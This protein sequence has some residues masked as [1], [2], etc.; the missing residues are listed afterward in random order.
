[1]SI[2]RTECGTIPR[3]AFATER[4]FCPAIT[5]AS[6]AG[7]SVCRLQ[8]GRD[9]GGRVVGGRIDCGRHGRAA[10]DP[11]QETRHYVSKVQKA[12]SVYE[13]LYD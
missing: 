6:V 3:P 4:V 1:M 7:V 12:V 2:R 8:C 13:K 10:Q 11:L 5:C 9:P